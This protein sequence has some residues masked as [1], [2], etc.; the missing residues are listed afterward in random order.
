MFHGNTELK[1][2]FY[3]LLVNLL[4]QIMD[5]QMPRVSVI[6][7]LYNQK[8]YLVSCLRSILNQTYKNLEII[9][10]NDGS[11]DDS[12]ATARALAREDNRIRV[13]DKQNEGVAYARR[14]GLMKATG[15]FV[16]FMD[17]DD[18]LPPDAIKTMV[19]YILKENVDLVIGQ[20][21]RF[22]GF[23][24][25]NN[26]ISSFP[27]HQ[28]VSQPELFDK[29]YGSFFGKGSFPNNVWGRLYRKS[30]IDR[31]LKD[32]EL[33]SPVIRCMADDLYMNMK[34]FPY[35]QSMYMTDEVVYYYRYGGTVDHYN[36]NYPEVFV[37]SDQRFKLLE[38]QGLSRYYNSLFVEY[39]NMVYYHAEQM[40]EFKHV[41]KEEVIA[42][43]KKELS[44]RSI[45]PRLIQYYEEN[46]TNNIGVKYLMAKNYEG[47]YDYAKLSL[48]QRLNRP[49]YRAKRL[50]LTFIELFI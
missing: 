33:Y 21:K 1:K 14:D 19:G 39:V 22:L 15:E 4:M 34:L 17:N 47:M 8:R 46:K 23:V 25:W 50:L 2:S 9:V 32:T 26:P 40:L 45:V 27:L 28:V 29:Y 6:V 5:A 42:F 30:A 18:L 49:A 36:K 20:Y 10:I 24:K 12:P 44:S 35:L 11:T 41:E 31:A 13:F 43:F 38:Q 37:I 16:T 48:R 3:V 7:P